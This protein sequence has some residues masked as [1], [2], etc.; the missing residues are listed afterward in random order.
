MIGMDLLDWLHSGNNELGDLDASGHAADA[1]FAAFDNPS[2]LEFG[3]AG[4]GAAVGPGGVTDHCG[5]G[6]NA[7]TCPVL[8]NSA[9]NLLGHGDYNGS[10][11]DHRGHDR[12]SDI[13]GLHGMS[14]SSVDLGGGMLNGLSNAVHPG[15]RFE[16]HSSTF[17]P[18]LNTMPYGLSDL[19]DEVA[20]LMQQP[21]AMGYYVSTAPAGPLPSW[22][23]AA[24]PHASL[25]FP[26]CLKS[27]L[28]LQTSLVG[29]D[30]AAAAAVGTPGPPPSAG[31]GVGSGM[32]PSD[33]PNHSLDSTSTCD[34]LRY[35]LEAYNALSWLTV[36]PVTNDRRS[37]LPIHMLLLC[38][39]YH[40][41]ESFT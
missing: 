34:V 23:W 16:S 1:M 7:G 5:S 12:Q 26:V 10:L 8:G 39:Q 9:D 37:C 32:A 35:V 11:H 41:I 21:L 22:F 36:N 19:P 4:L 31:P 24:C 3:L 40:A 33:R 15:D 18:E 27:A 20:N 13:V 29:M 28:H 6:G 14:S 2:G 17:G 30:D 38:Q 25:Q